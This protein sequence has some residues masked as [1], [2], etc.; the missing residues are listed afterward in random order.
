MVIAGACGLSGTSSVLIR[1]RKALSVAFVRM[2]RS[3][4]GVSAILTSMPFE[5]PVMEASVAYSTDEG[6]VSAVVS[7]R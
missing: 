1:E 6:I 5:A 4:P 2:Y 7:L 3:V